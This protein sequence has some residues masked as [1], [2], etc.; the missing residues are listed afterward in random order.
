MIT[1]TSGT[2]GLGTGDMRLEL[3]DQAGQPRATNEDITFRIV[4]S[5]SGVVTADSMTVTVRKGHYQSNLSTVRYV[6]PGSAVLQAIDD[7]TASFAYETGASDLITVSS[8]PS[9]P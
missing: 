2:V 1:Q 3:R 5:S 7:R 4:S 8:P 9:S 6:G